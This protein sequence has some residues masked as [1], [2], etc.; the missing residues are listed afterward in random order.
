MNGNSISTVN[1]KAMARL[2]VKSH[3]LASGEMILAP[4]C[5]SVGRE[6]E[7]SILLPHDSVS[8]RHCEI[9]LM[10]D[11]V[12]VRDLES[13]NG[14]FINDERVTEAE[15]K[16]GQTLRVGDVE[17]VLYDA[18]VRITVPDLTV[19]N[20]PKQQAYLEDGTPS[21]LRHDGVAAKFQCTGRC[22]KTFC[23]ECVRELRV[24]G[25][26][27]KRFCSECGGQCERIAATVREAKRASW[28]NKI[29]DA[30]MKP[31]SRR[32]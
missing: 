29:R 11:A 10:E 32:A 7:H 4:G 2:E 27:P 31:P 30:F 9:W 6:G 5:N 25:G 1:A 26:A 16:E 22:G 14:T 8:R 18:P 20:Q 28:L 3:D 15:L 19:P 12:L 17:L 24:A 13:R 21:C 23:G